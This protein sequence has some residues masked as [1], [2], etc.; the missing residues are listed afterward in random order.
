MIVRQHR[1][2]NSS[3]FHQGASG[4]QNHQGGQP[5]CSAAPRPPT[6][7]AQS[8]PSAEAKKETGTKPGS[9]FNCG[10]HGHFADKCPKPRRAGP[11][12]VQAHVNH[13]S[14][15][16]AQPAPEV[17]LG[18]FPINSVP[19][20]VLFDSG[21]THSFISKKFVG[22]HGL[23]KEELS[24]PM[25]VHTPGNSSTLVSYSPSVLIEIHR[26]RFLANLI[27]L[28]SKDLDV[29]L[30]M[31]WMTKFKGVIDCANRT[32]TLTNE[33]G[34]TVVY[35]SPVSRKQGISL[36][37]IEVE[38]PVAIEEKS[39]RKLEDIS[40]VC[41]YPEVF[42]EDLTTMPPKREIEF[43]IDLA[44]GTAPIYKRPYRM[45]ANELAEV[46]KQVDE[47]LQ[48]GYIRPSTSP[49]GAPVIFVQKK[50][51]TKRMCV[52]YRALNEVTIK[53]KYPLPRIDDLFEQLKG[54]KVFSKIDL[55]SGYHQL[56]IREEDISKTAFTT[57]FGLY[58]CTVM[59]FGLTNAPAFFMN[60]MNKVFMEF[61]DKFVVV[62]IDDILIY[63]KSEEEHEQ[64][65]RLVL[66]ELKEQQLY[67]KFSKCDFWLSED[68]FLGHVITA[69]GIAV[70]PANVES[71]TKWTPPKTVSQIRSF[72][73]LAGYYRR[74]IE[75]FSRIARPMTQLL[76]KDEK[77]KWTAECDKSFE[78]LKKKLVSAP[79]LILPDQ[80]K[81]FQVY[82]DAS[83]HG[84]GCVLMQEGRVVAFASRNRCEVYTDHKSLKYIFT[85]PDLNLRQRRW[86][87]LIKDY[88]MS[89]HYHPGKANVVA[90]ALSRKSYCNALCTEGMCKELQQELERLNMGIVEHGFVAALEARPTLVD[91]VRAAQV[92]DPEIAEL[93]KNMRVRKAR[94]ILED[95][96]GMIWMGERLCVPDDK[97]LNDLILTEAHQTQYSIHPGSTKMY[98]DLKEKFW[99]ASMKREIAE[100]V[101]LCDVC[102]R[103]KAEHQRPAGLLQ[104]LQ[105]PE[106][107]WEEIGM[108]FITGLPRTSSGHDSIWVV[109][110]RLTKVAHFIPVHTTYT[111]KSSLTTTAIRPVYIWRRS[112]RCTVGSVNRSIVRPLFWDQT[113]ERQLFG[114][115]VLTEAE[116]KVRTVRERLRIAQSRQKSYADNLR[117]ELTFEAGDYVYLRVTPLRGVHRFQTK[118]KLAP[119]FVGPYRILE[120]R[121]EVAYQLELPSNMI[122]IHDVFHVSQLKKCLRVPEEQA[123][124]EHINIQEDLTYVEK[125][126]RI[127]ETSER[128][129]RNKVTRFCRVQWSHHSD[130]EATLERED[131]LKAAHPHLFTS[132]SESRGRDSV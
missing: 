47:Q 67:A 12:F 18:T 127:L 25:R 63:S 27:L 45:V 109:V 4:S 56:R 33:K 103:V 80:T 132:S 29:I 14:A 83:R 22:I 115:E 70:D 55:R 2:F 114:T 39:S 101:A 24:T 81:D 126:V 93:K 30:G 23:R 17:V 116:E 68:K 120:R 1:P 94:D 77:F 42:P 62:F 119:R 95:E 34:E 66:E 26:S 111:G 3:S 72:L 59:S 104:P 79:V 6:A 123:D 92:N 74:F 8:A 38:N 31:D 61:L 97:E 53:N 89:I 5:N 91:Q 32:V 40:I 85:Q 69:Q 7:P 71:V 50:D 102:Q 112:K 86:L 117:R 110:D 96:H 84:L 13:A 54:A 82:C 37:Q 43:R 88:D 124:S 121:G 98:Q 73:G 125:P 129:T 99:W 118:G 130:E 122:G 78:E 36:N 87:E 20:T 44:P 58:E 21:A 105:I 11:R 15:E 108:D 75:I 48:K 52:D 64:H 106:W 51:K 60:L 131:E 113:G 128:R 65:L 10:E 57:R 35:K 19:A 76:K 100:F 9:C 107:K 41:E 46:K 16:E 49:W 90:D 28:E